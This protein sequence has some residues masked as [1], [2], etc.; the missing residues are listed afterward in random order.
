MYSETVEDETL[1]PTL[2][3]QDLIHLAEMCVELVQENNEHYAEVINH[4]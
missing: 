1:H 3:L 2:K 4:S